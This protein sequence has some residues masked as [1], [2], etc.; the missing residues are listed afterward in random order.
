MLKSIF[1]SD[2][3]VLS[4]E[5]FPPK[6]NDDMYTIFKT[7]D[8][9]QTYHPD[10]ISV[11]YGAG[12]STSK[13]TATIAAYIQNIC[14]IEALAHLTSVAMDEA[15]LR[16]M[17]HELNAKGV[18]N[19]LALRGDQPR[20]MSDEVFQ[21]RH[22]KHASD[23]IPIIQDAAEKEICIAAA[24]YPEKHPESATIED[25]L[26]Y[27]KKKA[28]AGIDFFITQ[29]FFDNGKFFE[30]RENA[31]AH[32]IQTPITAGIMP[33]TSAKQIGTSVQL[34]GS[35]VPT[36]LSNLLAKYGDNPEDMQKAGI[37]YAIRQIEQLIS[38]QVDGIHLYTMNKSDVTREIF[39]QIHVMQ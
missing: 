39:K 4:C 23:I 18:Y 20:D 26:T 5:V 21:N 15:F 19:V 33:I 6:R 29:M 35:S 8:E 37:D 16:Q 24:C 13:K 36:E 17:V 31:R 7:L 14:E 3:T 10:F 25:D 34:S 12:G 9:I 30:F 1:Q 2:K 22:F 28:D 11:T 38:N 27:L 32:G